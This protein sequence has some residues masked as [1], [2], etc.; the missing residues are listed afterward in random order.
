MKLSDYIL[1]KYEK[2]SSALNSDDIN[3]WVIEWYEIEFKR[4]PPIWL[5]ERESK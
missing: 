1:D 4:A 5:A 3:K 2:S